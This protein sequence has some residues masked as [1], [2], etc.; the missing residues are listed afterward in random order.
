MTTNREM[1]IQLDRSGF[2]IGRHGADGIIGDDTRAAIRAFEAAH[3]LPVDGVPD[4]A[5]MA[6]L[7]GSAGATELEHDRMIY[8]GRARYPVREIVLHC[9]ALSNP[10]RF[11]RDFPTI[12]EMIAEVSRWHVEDNG[13]RD[14]GYHIV[15]APG[16]DVGYGRMFHE[17]GAHV[18]EANRGTI[19]ILMLEVRKID[20]M[21]RF[22]DFFTEAQRVAVHGEI[23]KLSALTQ[24]KRITGHNEYAPKLCPGFKVTSADWITMRERRVSQERIAV[25]AVT[26]ARR[27]GHRL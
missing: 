4:A 17:I 5:F 11:Y 24:I 16:G 12:E 21:G 6:A 3:G 19:G 26:N 8:Q 15:C 1:Q 10:D 7:F 14:I 9:A 25:D 27:R 22:E 13:W 20:R 23:A 18:R 2:D